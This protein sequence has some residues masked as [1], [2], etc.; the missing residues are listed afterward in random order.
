MNDELERLRREVERL[1]AER[2]QAR[3]ELADEGER[4]W[5]LLNR[6]LEKTGWSLLVETDLTTIR[7]HGSTMSEVLAQFDRDQWPRA[8]D[9]A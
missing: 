1:T 7:K 8:E 5:H 2:D 9:E 6:V 3:A 4:H